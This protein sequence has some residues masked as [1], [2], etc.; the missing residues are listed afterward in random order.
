MSGF[1]TIYLELMKTKH[2]AAIFFAK[3]VLYLHR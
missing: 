2:N 1:F 3:V